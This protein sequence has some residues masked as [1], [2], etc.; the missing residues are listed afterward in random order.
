M[1]DDGSGGRKEADIEAAYFS[2]MH[3]GA[4]LMQQH[5]VTSLQAANGGGNSSFDITAGFPY[6]RHFSPHWP[7]I[8]GAGLLSQ[9][10]VSELNTVG[11]GG[12]EPRPT[13]VPQWKLLDVAQHPALTETDDKIRIVKPTYGVYDNKR[14]RQL[15]MDGKTTRSVRSKESPAATEGAFDGGWCG[16]CC[17]RTGPCEGGLQNTC[18]ALPN[19]YVVFYGRLTVQRGKLKVSRFG[20]VLLIE[21]TIKWP[22]SVDRIKKVDECVPISI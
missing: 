18:K 13:F 22:D 4:T 6:G 15:H 12:L 7:P 3:R 8:G 14:D 10:Q 9:Q 2:L 20:S 1:D 17:N 16:S 19:F 21:I 11:P 5:Q